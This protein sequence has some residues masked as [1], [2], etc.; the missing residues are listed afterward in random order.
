M[1]IVND[2]KK[3]K[4][5]FLLHFIKK[6]TASIKQWIAAEKREAHCQVWWCTPVIPALKKC[7]AEGS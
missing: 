1:N 7:E 3:L 5:H 2:I 6:S 4:L